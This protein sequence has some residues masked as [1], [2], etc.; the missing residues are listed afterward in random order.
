MTS[1]GLESGYGESLVL[2]GVSIRVETEELVS[3]I[4]PNG[5]GKSTLLKTLYG[6]LPVRSGSVRLRGEDI[7]GTRADR[8]TRRGVNYV[9]QLENVFPSLSVAENLKVSALPVQ[10]AERA[11]ALGGSLAT[12]NR[13]DGGFRVEARLPV[14]RSD[15]EGTE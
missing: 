14:Q 4:G 10:R 9:P 6:L 7:T 8:L 13:P 2:R 3:V 15:G 1:G 5:A 11:A 12:G